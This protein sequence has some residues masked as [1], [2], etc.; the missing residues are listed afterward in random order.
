MLPPG[1]Y[2]LSV[3]MQVLSIPNPSPAGSTFIDPKSYLT[4]NARQSHIAPNDWREVI[5]LRCNG[6]RA[7]R[8]RKE[9]VLLAGLRVKA[10]IARKVKIIRDRKHRSSVLLQCIIRAR[11]MRRRL[12]RRR[13]KSTQIANWYRTV[14]VWH[15][16]RTMRHGFM[17]IQS[18]FRG[19]EYGRKIAERRREKGGVLRKAGR[20]WVWRNGVFYGSQACKIQRSYRGFC[21]RRKFRKMVIDKK[22]ENAATV[23]QTTMFRGVKSR[24]QYRA[25]KCIAVLLIAAVR[26]NE[27]RVRVRKEHEKA[28]VIEK[29]WRSRVSRLVLMTAIR[30]VVKLQAWGRKHNGVKYLDFNR[31]KFVKIQ[32]FVRGVIESRR[33]VG[34][35]LA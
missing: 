5:F 26:G 10:V 22:G 19:Y 33:Y 16:W 11:G 20:F 14:I 17:T 15:K 4:R 18:N 8:K 30:A 31:R 3:D 24:H 6:V 13:E 9:M 7:A 23:I 1:T 27:L 32:A 29:Y 25:I 34:V 28:I 2:C 12:T 21:S 35:A